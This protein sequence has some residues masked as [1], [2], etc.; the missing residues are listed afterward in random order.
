MPQQHPDPFL[1][2]ILI[3]ILITFWTIE[4]AKDKQRKVGMR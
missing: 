4:E 1:K 2:T 3:S